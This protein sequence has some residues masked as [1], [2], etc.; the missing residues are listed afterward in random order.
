MGLARES[1]GMPVPVTS[2]LG[3]DLSPAQRARQKPLPLYCDPLGQEVPLLPP[4]RKNW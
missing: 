2:L 3:M 1:V 4:A